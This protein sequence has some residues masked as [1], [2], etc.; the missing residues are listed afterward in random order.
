MTTDPHQSKHKTVVP[1][2]AGISRDERWCLRGQRGGT[3]WLTGLSGTGK[4]TIAAALEAT[5]IR[6]GLDAVWLDGDNLR[7]ALCADLGFSEANRHENVRRIG[8]VARLFA[9]SGTVVIASVISP[10]RADRERTRQ[11]HQSDGIP[12]VEVLVEAPIEILRQRDPKG[13]YRRSLAGELRGLTGVDAPYER[14]LRAAIDLRTDLCGVSDA[15]AR[16]RSV[17]WGL[18]RP[19]SAVN[20]TD[21]LARGGLP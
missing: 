6:E 21:E 8:E 10:F 16:L 2:P 1:H 7:M 15:V 18:A 14:P 19:D 12:F 9:S 3:I 20:Q 17:A 11:A 4:S 5:L 13:L